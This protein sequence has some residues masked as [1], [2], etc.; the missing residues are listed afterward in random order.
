MGGLKLDFN[1]EDKV[2][3]GNPRARVTLM[4]KDDLK[5]E[6]LIEAEDDENPMVTA[7]FR[8]RKG[9]FH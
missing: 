7:V 9:K 8:Q 4:I 2:T 1:F 5:Y 6:R 3:G